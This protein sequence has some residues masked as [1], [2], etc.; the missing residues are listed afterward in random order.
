[1][2]NFVATNLIRLDWIRYDCIDHKGH[3]GYDNIKQHNKNKTNEA[4]HIDECN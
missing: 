2:F 4:H 3:L 1:M